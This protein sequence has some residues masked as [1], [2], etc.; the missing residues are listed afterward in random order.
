ML[1]D[2]GQTFTD[3]GQHAVAVAFWTLVCA[4]QDALTQREAAL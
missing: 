1:D 2:M 3:I 4:C